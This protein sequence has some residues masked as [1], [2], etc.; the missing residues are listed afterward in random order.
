MCPPDLS[1][2]ASPGAFYFAPMRAVELP[3]IAALIITQNHFAERQCVHSLTRQEPL[4]LMRELQHGYAQNQLQFVVGYQDNFLMATLGCEFDAALGRAWLRGPFVATD[5]ADLWRNVATQLWAHLQQVLP[6]TIECWDAFLNVENLEGGTFYQQ[7]SFRWVREVQFYQCSK[8][9]FRHPPAMDTQPE[10]T[11]AQLAEIASL[12]DQ[13]FPK[14][15][16][17]G[18]QLLANQSSSQRLFVASAAGQM[19]GYVYASCEPESQEGSIEFV[20]IHP[21][22]RRQGVA[23]LLLKQAMYWLFNDCD[24][25]WVSLNVQAEQHAAR[26]LY[27][28]VG[29]RLHTTGNHW[30]KDNQ[31]V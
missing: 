31:S 13:L 21:D 10:H 17:S 1:S 29:F 4:A 23:T 14:T 6:V 22:S 20:G 11:S 30:R 7:Q 3:K 5:S 19:Q 24:C 27:E 8:S 12:H 26:T 9:N 18:E 2:F 25:H 28:K 16:L 15:Y